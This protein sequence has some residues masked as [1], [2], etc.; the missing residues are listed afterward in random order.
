M[1]ALLTMAQSGV[2][3]VGCQAVAARCLMN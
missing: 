3:D 2:D 1:R